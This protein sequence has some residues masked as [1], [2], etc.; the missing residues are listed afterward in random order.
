M[1]LLPE[2]VVHLLIP[3]RHLFHLLEVYRFN[4]IVTRAA[5]ILII[6]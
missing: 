2:V 3:P 5:I 1:D 4:F 6:I